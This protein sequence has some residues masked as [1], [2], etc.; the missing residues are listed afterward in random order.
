MSITKADIH[1]SCIDLAL[2]TITVN[3]WLKSFNLL[4]WN[5]YKEGSADAA[6][7]ADEIEV[8]IALRSAKILT[9][10]QFISAISERVN[11]TEFN[12]VQ[13]AYTIKV[14]Q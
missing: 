9:A 4:S 14:A 2:G 11:F 1:A 8:L 10:E 12:G 13:T 6:K 3:E 7:E 5:I